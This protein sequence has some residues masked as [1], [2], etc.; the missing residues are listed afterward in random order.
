M[1]QVTTQT[2]DAYLRLR[3]AVGILGMS[4]PVVLLL[5]GRIFDGVW[6][7]TSISEYHYSAMRDYFGA[8]LGTIGLFLFYYP[9]YDRWD[10]VAS[11]LA[12]IGAWGVVIIYTTPDTPS[13]CA[14]AGSHVADLC[15]LMNLVIEHRAQVHLVFATLFFAGLTSF[16]FLFRKPFQQPGFDSEGYKVASRISAMPD[17]M[18]WALIPRY[19]LDVKKHQSFLSKRTKNRVFL[20][21]GWGM[22]A[23]LAAIVIFDCLQTCASQDAAVS[24]SWIL[25]HWV[26]LFESLAVLLFGVAWF[27]KGEGHLWVA[28]LLQGSKHGGHPKK[29]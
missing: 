29:E 16:C 26:Y 19:G 21:C 4:L 24:C 9:G 6:G 27:V 15:F 14:D 7:Q 11:W 18:H 22:L 10:R 12:C 28:Q 23:C 17:W 5:F 3:K 25:R 13:P 2:K 1:K 20:F 8:T